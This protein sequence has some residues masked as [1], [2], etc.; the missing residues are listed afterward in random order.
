MPQ[1]VEDYLRSLNT[2]DR[3]R[4]S[5]WDAVYAVKDDAQAQQLLAQLP[6]SDDVKATLWDARKGQKPSTP[7]APTPPER[8]WTDAAVGALPAVGGALGGIVGGIGGTVGGFG[9]GGVPGAVGGAAIGGAGGEAAKQL[10][11]RMR[12]AEAPA[13]P[14]QAASGIGRE[15]AVQGG[16]ELAGRGVMKGAQMAAHGLMDFAIRPAPTV[17][18]E[19]GDIAATAL[20][21]RLPVGSV[22]PGAT[23]GSQA[24]VTA[25]QASGRNTSSL[26]DAA[27]KAGTTFSPGEIAL[28]PVEKLATEI[29]KEPLHDSE[30]RQLSRLFADY[31]NQQP[32]SLSPVAT[33]EMKGAAQRIAK[34]IF[35]ALNSGNVVP[36]GD[37]LKASFN[38]AIADGAKGALETIPGVAESE[39]RTQSLIGATKAIKRAEVR[40]LPL[41]VETAAPL[42]GAVAGGARG[43]MSGDPRQ[44]AEGAGAGITAAVLTRAL[45]SPR[46]TSRAALGLTEP[47]IQEALRQ[48]PRAS[49]YALLD[50]LQQGSHD[51]GDK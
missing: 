38:K 36:A 8:S 23:K 30:L 49:V 31:L 1:Q 20:R 15:A 13:T 22:L 6:F 48:M 32:G 43:V 34:P 29:A 51:Q 2:S 24:A 11:N 37:S 46:S 16:S 45:L 21:E 35:R 26:L 50:D 7:T 39:A 40:R 41:V 12:G 47:A 3:A 25:R 18:E 19:F 10:I 17:A 5:A 4:A 44:T 9:V 27:G 42:I 14:L 28:H 33:K